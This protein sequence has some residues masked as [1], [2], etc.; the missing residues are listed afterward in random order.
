MGK[1]FPGGG[2]HG[3]DAADAA[4]GMLSPV[5]R[6]IPEEES[7]PLRVFSLAEIQAM[8]GLTFHD[9]EGRMLSAS[10]GAIHK[11]NTP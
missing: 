11:E 9:L 8:S 7:T 1:C 4:A 3:G 5:G 10:T 2:A 6:I